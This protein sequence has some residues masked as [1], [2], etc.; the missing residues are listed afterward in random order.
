MEPDSN[1]GFFYDSEDT[2]YEIYTDNSG[3]L[4]FLK[5]GETN[6]TSGIFF[7]T[8]PGST[9]TFSSFQKS[10][11]KKVTKEVNEEESLNDKITRETEEMKAEIAG[12]R[13]SV[14]EIAT[15]KATPKEIEDLAN[16]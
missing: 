12:V 3:T 2:K 13:K 7:G 14:M 6:T 9:K 5:M 1:S 11:K 15:L 8:S 4:N 16:S 10:L